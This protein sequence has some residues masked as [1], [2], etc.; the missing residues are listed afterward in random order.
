MSARI[1]SAS[2]AISGS[3]VSTIICPTIAPAMYFIAETG[4]RTSHSRASSIFE[5][6]AMCLG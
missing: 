4:I 2:I 1:Q 3:K 5:R 6:C